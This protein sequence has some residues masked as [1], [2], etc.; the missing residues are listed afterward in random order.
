MIR[1]LQAVIP[2]ITAYEG[3]GFLV[4]R[5]FPTRSLAQIDPFLLLDEMGP[6]NLAPGEAKG[7]SDHPHR[8]FEI[9]TYM[10]SGAIEH[11]DSHGHRGGMAAGDAQYMLAGDGVVHAEQPSAA[12]MRDGGTMHGI[13]LWINLPAR[14]KRLRPTYRDLRANAVPTVSLPA[15]AGSVS[16]LAGSGF[17]LVSP[18]QT[19]HPVDYYRLALR[20]GSSAEVAVSPTAT[21]IAYPIAG[22]LH[23]G[24]RAIA[25]GEL[26]IFRADGD[27]VR[28]TNLGDT[29]LDTFVLA[30]API[31]E[32]IARYGPFVMSTQAEIEETVAA[33]QSGRFG[34]IAALEVA[35]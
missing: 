6:M 31:G 2:S 5:P 19:Q 28:L 15:G 8:G 17:G 27:V 4:H 13:Q 9:I 35:L 21:T 12:M 20:P 22:T 18:L 16:I 24:T 14:D 32:P 1:S 23:I 34:T 26:V 30:S 7:A 25:R 29:E 11:A 3:D 33:Y 10:I